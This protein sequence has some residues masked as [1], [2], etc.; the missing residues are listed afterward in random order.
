MSRH[1]VARL[2]GALA[3][4]I[5]GWIHLRLYRRSYHAISPIGPLFAVDV[6]TAAGITTA[7]VLRHDTIVAAVGVLHS[8]GALSGFVLSRTVGL[9]GFKESWL[10]PSPETSLT[11]ATETLAVVLLI[12]GARLTY[13]TRAIAMRRRTVH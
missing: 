11:L 2:L 9:F 10:Q 5:G 1:T 7:L 8:I 3:V 13:H 4:G 12:Y 6:V